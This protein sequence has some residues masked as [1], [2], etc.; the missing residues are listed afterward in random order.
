MC[1]FEDRIIV[2]DGTNQLSILDVI[3]LEPT[4]SIQV[5]SNNSDVWNLNEL[6]A[7]ETKLC[8]SVDVA[9]HTCYFSH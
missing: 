2:S 4:E 7:S 6:S 8:K 9:F 5:T 1:S 3:T